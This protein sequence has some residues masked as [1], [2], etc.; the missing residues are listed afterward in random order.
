MIYKIHGLNYEVHFEI[1][2]HTACIKSGFFGEINILKAPLFDMIIKECNIN[3][4]YF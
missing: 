1:N 2:Q 4:F 3:G